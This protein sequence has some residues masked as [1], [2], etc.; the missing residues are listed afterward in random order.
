MAQASPPIESRGA[1]SVS[2]PLTIG[3]IIGGLAMIGLVVSRVQRQGGPL[4]V[5]LILG[6]IFALIVVI[7]P[8]VGYFAVLI[9]AGF[10]RIKIGTGTQSPIVA[11]LACGVVLL[12]GWLLHGMLHRR[13]L[14]FLP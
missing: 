2:S 7:R 12:G 3:L 8:Q 6:L 1:A 9:S 13:R 4:P 11:S 14:N 5:I 10:L